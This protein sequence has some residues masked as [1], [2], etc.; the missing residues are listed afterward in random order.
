MNDLLYK[1][2]ITKIPKVGAVTAKNLIS[3]CGGAKSVFEATRKELLRIPNIGATMANTILEQDVLEA[4]AQE[5]SFIEQHDIKVLYYLNEDYPSRL[6]PY[7]DSPPVLYY[8]GTSNLNTARIVGIV[9]TRK[10]TVHGVAMC[11]EIVSQLQAYNVMVVSGLAYGIDV[12]AHRQCLKIN[13]ETVGVMGSGLGR[14][15]PAQHRQTAIQMAENGGILTEYTHDQGPDRE[16]FP[17]RNR[18]IAGLCDALI[19][20]ET[21]TK[22]GSMISANKALDYNKEVFALPGR[23]KD[24]SSKGCNQ[25]IKQNKAML[26]TSGEDVAVAMNWDKAVGN[27]PI[28]KLLFVELN[29]QERQIVGLMKSKEAIGVDVL[30]YRAKVSTGKLAAILLE[31]ELK[32][33]IKSLP[34]KRY[35]LL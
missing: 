22:G 14:I 28:Q 11:E 13:M 27:K 17:A 8:K 1:I 7:N 34:G 21:A 15:Y 4:A 3:Y 19:V 18:I 12:T 25:L 6:K 29:E 31:L 24:E 5:L 32:G 23:A 2:A 10:P 16:H 35:I 33:L 9:G 30:S 26:I 20:V